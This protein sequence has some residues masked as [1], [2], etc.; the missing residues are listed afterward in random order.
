MDSIAPFESWPNCPL[1]S[2]VPDR[3]PVTRRPHF[4]SFCGS[5]RHRIPRFKG[6]LAMLVP[7]DGG[8][9]AY[10]NQE[11]DSNRK[12]VQKELT[13]AFDCLMWRMDFKHVHTLLV[14]CVAH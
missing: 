7:F 1:A 12:K 9:Y 10:R 3:Y 5:L 11:T 13:Y 4:G 14:W 2:A 8:L 6:E